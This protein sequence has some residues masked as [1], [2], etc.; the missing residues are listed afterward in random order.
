MGMKPRLATVA[1]QRGEL[2]LL[3]FHDARRDGRIDSHEAA[4]IADALDDWYDGT[5]KADTAGALAHALERG[6]EKECYLAEMVAEY[7][8]TVLDDLPAA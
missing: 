6:V 8:E 3:V 4:S 5:V 1:R 2:A 7:R